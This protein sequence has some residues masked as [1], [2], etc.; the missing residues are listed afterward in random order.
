MYS[1]FQT[2][3]YYQVL[4]MP[5]TVLLE[6]DVSVAFKELIFSWDKRTRYIL[7][8]HKKAACYGDLMKNC[9]ILLIVSSV[10]PCSILTGA[11]SCVHAVLEHT[12]AKLPRC[13]LLVYTIS[14]LSHHY[15]PSLSVCLHS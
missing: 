7:S 12:N 13:S 8:G 15:F 10:F 9:N 1:L 3:I 6:E 4:T 2:S 14:H 11:F 5:G